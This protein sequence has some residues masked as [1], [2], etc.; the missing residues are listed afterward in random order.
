MPSTYNKDK[1]WD[2]EDIDKWKIDAFKPGDNVAGHFVEES[3]F[4]TLFPKVGF[5][6]LDTRLSLLPSPS[7][8]SNA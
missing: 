1:P 7:T 3:T 8:L 5:D 4:A 2:T 6:P